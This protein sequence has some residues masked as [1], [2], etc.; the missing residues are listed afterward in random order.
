VPIHSCWQRFK[1]SWRDEGLIVPI[2]ECVAMW[3]VP[4]LACST[5]S[6]CTT[7][8][9]NSVAKFVR[10]LQEI[11]S[12]YAKELKHRGCLNNLSGHTMCHEQQW[13]P[14]TQESVVR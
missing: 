2:V 10:T 13:R 7:A 12:N 6:N 5:P 4:G 9:K 14:C 11:V 3:E 1:S 8:K